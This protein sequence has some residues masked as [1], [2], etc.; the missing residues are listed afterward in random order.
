MSDDSTIKIGVDTSKNDV[1]VSI[2]DD[3]GLTMTINM[4]PATAYMLSAQLKASAT[5]LKNYINQ[6]EEEDT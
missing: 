4:G 1:F 2:T 3:S 6:D 5:V